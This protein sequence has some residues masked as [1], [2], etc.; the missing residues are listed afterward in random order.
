MGRH[1]HA[2]FAELRLMQHQHQGSLSVQAFAQPGH[3]LR[4]LVPLLLACRLAFQLALLLLLPLLLARL[5]L[6]D[7]PVPLVL[8]HTP[9]RCTAGPRATPLSRT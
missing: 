8:V 4:R 5:L 9:V 2:G 7:A 3:E 1:Q 6:L